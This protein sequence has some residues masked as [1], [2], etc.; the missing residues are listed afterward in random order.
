MINRSSITIN[1]TEYIPAK[2][3]DIT[4]LV[5]IIGIITGIIFGFFILKFQFGTSNETD[6]PTSVPAVL[7][8][9]E[10]RVYPDGPNSD[11]NTVQSQLEEQGV[12]EYSV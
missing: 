9:A 10:S 1:N 12:K 3:A 4:F 8:N 11:L 6:L 2:E 7:N 5:A